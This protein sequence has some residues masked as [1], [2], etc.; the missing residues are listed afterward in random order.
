MHGAIL[1]DS[2]IQ[3]CQAAGFQPKIVKEVLSLQSRVCLV[4]SGLGVTFVTDRLQFL[5]GAHVI[6]RPLADC[7]IALHLAAAWRNNNAAPPLEAF[8]A[9]LQSSSRGLRIQRAAHPPTAPIQDVRV[10]DS[11]AAEIKNKLR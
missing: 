10:C 11:F 3:I 4:A 6:C 8:L 1:Y 9:I 7:P 5:V 2:F